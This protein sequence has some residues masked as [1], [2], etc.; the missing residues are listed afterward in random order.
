METR[1][2]RGHTETPLQPIN[3]LTALRTHRLTSRHHDQAASAD[4]A[5]AEAADESKT[6]S[7]P[8]NEENELTQEKLNRAADQL[9]ELTI[10]QKEV[11]KNL[12][13]G[14]I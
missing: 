4:P 11:V 10:L 13:L 12:R 2:R 7:H 6:W 9:E 8:F 14:A 5:A 1:I 3:P